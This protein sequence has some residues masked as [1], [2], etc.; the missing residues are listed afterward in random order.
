M[1][2]QLRS[3]YELTVG[4]RFGPGKDDDHE[5]LVLDGV[6]R[7]TIQGLKYDADLWQARKLIRNTELQG[8][9]AV[10]TPGVKPLPH[11]LD[12]EQPLSMAEFT[13]FRG[14]AARANYLGPDRPDMI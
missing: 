4:A 13:R 2:A 9:N 1:E 3:K 14:Q 12:E 10:T 5:G 8:A 6:V 11:Q 7:W